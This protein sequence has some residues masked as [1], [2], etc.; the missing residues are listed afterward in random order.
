[1]ALV[2]WSVIGF[3]L[4]KVGRLH[5]HGNVSQRTLGKTLNLTVNG[6]PPCIREG[7]NLAIW[8]HDLRASLDEHFRS[9]LGIQDIF[10]RGLI[11]PQDTHRLAVTV[12]LKNCSLHHVGG[13]I[14]CESHGILLRSLLF[15]KASL[16]EL[17]VR[18]AQLLRQDSDGCFCRL[19]ISDEL[20]LIV[21]QQ[22]R[23]VTHAASLRQVDDGFVLCPVDGQALH[24]TDRRIVVTLH[25]VGFHAASLRHGQFHDAHF[26]GCESASFVRANDSCA[27]QC[28]HR[29]QFSDNRI[30][31]G[32]LTSSE[33]KACSDHCRQALWDGCN[34]QGNC[35]L[36]VVDAAFQH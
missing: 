22:A 30:A 35:N 24:C 9:A 3:Q 7:F 28:L 1:M 6:L 31:L 13:P 34:S 23:L 27:A 16:V 10:S 5:S 26:V 21:N 12:E 18:A 19:A 32:H 4:S 29:G 15:L 25:V 33:S 14:V 8:Q 2:T 11:T 17:G 36:E 20:L